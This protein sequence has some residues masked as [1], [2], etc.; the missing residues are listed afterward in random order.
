MWGASS[1]CDAPVYACAVKATSQQGGAAFVKIPR[2]FLAPAL[3]T[4]W[5]GSTPL[6]GFIQRFAHAYASTPGGNDLCRVAPLLP[7]IPIRCMTMCSLLGLHPVRYCW[8][9]PR[10]ESPRTFLPQGSALGL[11]NGPP[12]HSCP[13]PLHAVERE[14]PRLYKET[15]RFRQQ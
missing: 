13:S 7:K 15:Q 9:I 4:Q 6:R 12:D 10:A 14:Q 3:S 5:R 1:V 11:C 2:I 8:R